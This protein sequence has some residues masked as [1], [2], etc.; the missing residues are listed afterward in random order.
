MKKL[1]I[2]LLPVLILSLTSCADTSYNKGQQGAG[3]GG[4]G[5]AIIGQAIGGDTEATLIGAAVGTMLGYIVGNEMDK[6]D[7]QRLNQTYETAPSGQTTRWSNPDNGN[8]Y[9][10]TPQPAYYPAPE[11]P[12][13]QAEI[14][15]T[16]DGKTEKTYTTACRN[17]AGQWELQN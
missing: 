6:Y 2:L 15:A 1:V 5:G 4:I 10:V 16:I 12:C 17:S 9:Q 11:R 8:V 7:R 14:L 13:R 3:I